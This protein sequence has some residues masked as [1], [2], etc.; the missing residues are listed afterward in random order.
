MAFTGSGS[1]VATGVTLFGVG[2]S[3]GF[4]FLA[5]AAILN[6]LK[7]AVFRLRNLEEF[8]TPKT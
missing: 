3:G 7:E 6:Y 2:I 8:A 1:E 5:L 4:V